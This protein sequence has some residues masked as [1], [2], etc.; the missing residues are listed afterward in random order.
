[1]IYLNISSQLDKRT[2][3]VPAHASRTLHKPIPVFHYAYA[4]YSFFLSLYAEY[5]GIQK[6]DHEGHKEDD[7]R[8]S[9][10]Y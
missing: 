8:Y 7:V 5:S 9:Y 1:M 2:R 4:E 10:W 6:K 3:N